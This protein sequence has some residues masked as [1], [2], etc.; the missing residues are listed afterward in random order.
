VPKADE[1]KKEL[2]DEVKNKCNGTD[3]KMETAKW[4]SCTNAN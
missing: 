3:A 1:V 4:R 2:E